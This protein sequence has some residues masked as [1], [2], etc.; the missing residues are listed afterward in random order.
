MPDNRHCCATLA[1]GSDIQFNTVIRAN[2]QRPRDNSRVA[3]GVD[4]RLRLR[5]QGRI[6]V[7]VSIWG[8]SLIMDPN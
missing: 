7:H 3:R 5:I 4:S 8:N 6:I 1:P 2:P